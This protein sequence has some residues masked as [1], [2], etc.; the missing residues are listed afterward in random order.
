MLTTHQ[1]AQRIQRVIE[2]LKYRRLQV[3]IGERNAAYDACYDAERDLVLLKWDLTRTA[4]EER[5][6]RNVQD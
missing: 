5:N 6:D 4:I 1:A 3:P 2:D